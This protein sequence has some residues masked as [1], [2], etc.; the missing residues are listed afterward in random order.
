MKFHCLLATLAVSTL[1]SLPA[2]AQPLRGVV[3]AG[4]TLSEDL[5]GYAGGVVSFPG[6][7]LGDGL[8]LKG[9]TSA[10][11]YEYE[12]TGSL[13]E[14]DYVGAELGL[15]YQKS[16]EWGWANVSAGPRFTHTNLS[17]ND[18]GN[19][20]RG[21]QW[22][23]GLQTDGALDGPKWRLGWYG[24]VGAFDGA[25]Q[26]QLRLGHR[27]TQDDL[28]I[29]V[30]GGILGDPSYTR[31]FGGLFVSKALGGH[32]EVLLSAGASDQAHRG[33]RAYGSISLSKLF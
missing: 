32:V 14:A 1:G 18:P 9:A 25:Y 23:L 4:A 8:A 6:A 16:G 26:A 2:Q 21:D 15:V 10:G 30:E 31:G 28:R 3:F 17:P 24:S 22:D 29:G 20:L 11:R 12:A 5:S 7:Q 27:V 33:P 19:A 13:I